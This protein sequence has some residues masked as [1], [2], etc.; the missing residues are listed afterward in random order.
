MI[1]TTLLVS[2]LRVVAQVGR[3]TDPVK[4]WGVIMSL[5]IVKGTDTVM[6]LWM[7]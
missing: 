1:P 4:L 5:P 7:Q 3:E 6:L 2:H